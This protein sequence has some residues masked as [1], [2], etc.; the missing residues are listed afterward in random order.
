MWKVDLQIMAIG[1]VGSALT[2]GFY[3]MALIV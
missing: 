2:Y 1:I 3:Y